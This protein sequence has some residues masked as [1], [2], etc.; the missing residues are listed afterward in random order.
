MAKF[1]ELFL[2]FQELFVKYQ[3]LFVDHLSGPRPAQ[4][5]IS[6]NIPPSLLEQALCQVLPG[7]VRVDRLTRKT[8]LSDTEPEI[9]DLLQTEGFWAFNLFPWSFLSRY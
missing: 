6:A 5:R 1:Q 3:E 2:K 7:Q 8:Q 9:M 4:E